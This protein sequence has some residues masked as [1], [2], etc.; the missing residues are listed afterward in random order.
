MPAAWVVLITA[1]IGLLDEWHQMF[2]PGRTAEINDFLADA[3]GALLGV[4]A[5]VIFHS[6]FIKPPAPSQP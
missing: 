4:A 2:I 6:C 1:A 5:C 3:A